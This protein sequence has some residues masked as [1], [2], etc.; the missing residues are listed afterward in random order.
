MKIRKALF[1][2]HANV[3]V[4]QYCWFHT[5]STNIL[6][7]PDTQGTSLNREDLST[8]KSKLVIDSNVSRAQT[9]VKYVQKISEGMYQMSQDLHQMS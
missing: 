9:F 2:M 5:F 3:I 6:S 8:K 4:S 7:L 1:D